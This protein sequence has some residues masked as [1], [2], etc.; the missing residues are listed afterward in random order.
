M[1]ARSDRSGLAQKS[2]EKGDEPGCVR[3]S[4]CDCSQNGG[5]LWSCTKDGDAS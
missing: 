2:C 4:L 3:K 5:A 1:L